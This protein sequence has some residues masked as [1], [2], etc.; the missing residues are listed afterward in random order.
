MYVII[1]DDIFW[2]FI[3]FSFVGLSGLVIDFGLTYLCKE[4]FKIQKFISNAIGFTVA[5]ANNYILNRIWTFHSKNPEI[6]TEFLSFFIISLIGLGINTLI[7]WILNNKL[8]VNFYISKGVAT[9]VVV[10]WNFFANLLVTFA[11]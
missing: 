4:I 7:I 6:T 8:H 9:I 10:L 3:K 11:K 1:I 2:K 5:A